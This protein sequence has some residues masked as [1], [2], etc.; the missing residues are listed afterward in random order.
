MLFFSD[1]FRTIINI[2]GDAL[3]ANIVSHF[4]K[5]DIKKKKERP[6][7]ENVYNAF[8]HLLNEN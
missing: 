4:Y 2:I 7:E 5:I 6:L 8:A 1:R 3:G